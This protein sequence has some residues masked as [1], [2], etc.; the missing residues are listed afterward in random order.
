LTIG[1]FSL[2]HHHTLSFNAGAPAYTID[3]GFNFLILDG[4]GVVNNSSNALI[5][6]VTAV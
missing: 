3:T 1:A 2:R 6:N 5:I 4:L